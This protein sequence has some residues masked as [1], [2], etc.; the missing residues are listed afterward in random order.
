MNSRQLHDRIRE[1]IAQ[2]DIKQMKNVIRNLA[3]ETKNFLNEDKYRMIAEEIFQK[4]IP[5]NEQHIFI[6][7]RLVVLRKELEE[8]RK[9]K[10]NEKRQLYR[11][12][13]CKKAK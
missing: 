9:K 10:T 13:F 8:E 2:W 5:I 1:E 11:Q 12:F 7:D 4:K 6:T 3:G